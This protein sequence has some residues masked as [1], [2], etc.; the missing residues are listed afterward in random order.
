M[1]RR[2]RSVPALRCLVMSASHSSRSGSAFMAMSNCLLSRRT[3]RIGYRVSVLSAS[4]S[5]GSTPMADSCTGTGGS[6]WMSAT[7]WNRK[8]CCFGAECESKSPSFTLSTQSWTSTLATWRS[9]GKRASESSC[10][11]RP[12]GSH[13]AP[14]DLAFH[15]M[16]FLTIFI[17]GEPPPGIAGLAASCCRMP[18]TALGPSAVSGAVARRSSSWLSRCTAAAV[19]SESTAK[20]SPSTVGDGGAAPPGGM[21]GAGSWCSVST[22]PAR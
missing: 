1:A 4:P 18:A 7:S 10:I 21:Y 9:I 11:S 17:V 15:T 5:A 19:L 13:R 2:R 8:V 16:P 3:R 12:R 20:C 6:G 14:L 22:G